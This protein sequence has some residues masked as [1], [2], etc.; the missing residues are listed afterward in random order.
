ME[1]QI[2]PKRIPRI[3]SIQDMARFWD[4]HDLT[5]FDDDLQEEINPVFRKEALVRIRLPQRKLEVIKKIAK[6][7]GVGYTELIRQWVDERVEAQ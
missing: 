6:S 4:E 1:K 7:K 2:T 3:D 5:D